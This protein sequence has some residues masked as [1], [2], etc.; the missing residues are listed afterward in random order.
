MTWLA[1]RRADWLRLYG[2]KVHD[3]ASFAD[4]HDTERWLKDYPD[5][6]RFM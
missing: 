4:N 3:M 2:D 5:T 6:S 1:D